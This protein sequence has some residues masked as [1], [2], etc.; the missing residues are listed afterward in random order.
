MAAVFAFGLA[1]ALHGALRL[2][3]P[4][5]ALPRPLLAAVPWMLAALGLLAA[6]VSCVVWA[7]RMLRP[8]H[9]VAIV[10]AHLLGT[11]ASAVGV[12]VSDPS[13][14]FGPELAARLELPGD[15]GHAYL[16]RGG[17][18]CSQ[19]IRVAAPGQWYSVPRPELGTFTCDREGTLR[20]DAV[21]GQPQAIDA[22][23]APLPGAGWEQAFG[24][25][26]DWRPH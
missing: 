18:L 10:V 7:R 21:R 2:A 26:L 20:W 5:G 17:V 13:F 24:E 12:L 23:G 6:I 25:G 16:Y 11:V 4:P 14:P 15:R 3:T 8:R 9:T 19:E 1:A 22:T